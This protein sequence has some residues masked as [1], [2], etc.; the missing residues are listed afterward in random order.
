MDENRSDG[1]AHSHGTRVRAHC[2]RDGAVR[3]VNGR[4]ESIRI[5]WGRIKQILNHQR[6]RDLA[7]RMAPE[8]VGYQG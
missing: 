3:T 5:G 8:P 7:A 1:R 6:T 2:V 4:H